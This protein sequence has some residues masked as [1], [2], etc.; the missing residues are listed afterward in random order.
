MSMR[1]S[2]LAVLT[3]A[4]SVLVGCESQ[5]RTPVAP[6]VR[7]A[8][9]GGGDHGGKPFATAMTQEV[10]THPTSHSGDPDGV[11]EALISVSLG[12]RTVCWELS[13]SGI[14]L[15]GT[16]AHIHKEAPGR[17]GPIVVGLSA[18]DLTGWATGCRSVENADLLQDILVDPAGYYVN[19]HN[20]QY[21]PGAIR[22]Q[23][24]R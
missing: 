24:E 15:P 4:L 3:V 9:V 12:Q 18:P 10:F 20:A 21:A 13:V 23:L 8:V 5:D 6:T 2:K 14:A 7:L 11:G 16:A 22:G 17:Q 19:V 1:I